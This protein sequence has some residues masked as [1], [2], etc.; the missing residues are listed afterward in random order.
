MSVTSTALPVTVIGISGSSSC[1]S[2]LT[3]IFF[4]CFFEFLS[5]QSINSPSITFL[6]LTG[7][8]TNFLFMYSVKAESTAASSL[9]ST[10]KIKSFLNFSRSVSGSVGPLKI[11]LSSFLAIF[12]VIVLLVTFGAFVSES[13]LIEYCTGACE[14]SK[15]TL[16]FFKICSVGSSLK[17]FANTDLRSST[18][19]A[20][21]VLSR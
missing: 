2:T 1:V 15:P 19:N 9:I 11:S 18:L 10:L 5:Y 13:T 17:S 7:S 14:P 20:S 16:I 12:E 4:N 8:V 21:G 3:S 6:T